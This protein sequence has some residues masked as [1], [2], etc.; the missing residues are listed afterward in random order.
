MIF[1]ITINSINTY[2][3]TYNWN[4]NPYTYQ[5]I[6]NS[7]NLPQEDRNVIKCYK[8]YKYYESG[9]W[10]VISVIPNVST[11]NHGITE[12]NELLFPIDGTELSDNDYRI[13]RH[14][15]PGLLVSPLEIDYNQTAQIKC[16]KDFTVGNGAKLTLKSNNGSN[17]SKMYIGNTSSTNCGASLILN[18]NPSHTSG[19]FAHL[20]LNPNCS[21]V[22]NKKSGLYLGYE[23]ILTLDG[24]SR[25]VCENGSY[26]CNYGA[27]I[28]G[29]GNS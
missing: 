24:G 25:I 21:L 18:S 27:R 13:P 29:P 14:D 8:Q 22:I 4:A 12:S 7:P 6:V 16:D 5:V 11:Y 3:I 15:N 9:V 28:S 17:I 2:G 1:Y 19:N 20:Y 26:Y 23:S 10:T